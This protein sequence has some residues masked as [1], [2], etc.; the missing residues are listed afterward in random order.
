MRCPFIVGQLLAKDLVLS[1]LLGLFDEFLDAGNFK[2]SI[3]RWFLAKEKLKGSQFFLLAGVNSY[4]SACAKSA[5]ERRNAP[6]ASRN[7]N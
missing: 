3:P 7:R 1:L 5:R 2:V 4:S 6:S